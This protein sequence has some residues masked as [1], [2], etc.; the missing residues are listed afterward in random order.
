MKNTWLTRDVALLSVAIFFSDASNGSTIPI[1]PGYAKQL[2]ASLSVLGTYGSVAAVA[3]LLLSIPLGRLSDRLGRKSVIIP[4]LAL[5]AVVQFSYT[6]ASNPLHLYPIRIALGVATGMIFVNG[7]LL[8]TEVADER[9]RSLAGGLYMT[10]MGLGFTLGPLAGGLTAKLYGP[11][12]SFMM[13]C[14]LAVAGLL[15]L[16]MVKETRKTAAETRGPALQLRELLRDP[17]ILASGVANF[18]NSLMFNAVTLF[19][20]VYGADIGLDQAQIGVGL[21]SRGLASTVVRLPVGAF[22]SRVGAL[23]LMVAGLVA[24]AVTLFS[25][26]YA[27]ALTLVTVLMGLQGLAYGVYLTSGNVY[28]SEEAPSGLKGTSMAIYGMFGNIGGIVGPL[29]LGVMAENAGTS[30]ALQ[31]A[32]AASVVGVGL[33]MLLSRRNSASPGLGS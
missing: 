26:S 16:L 27:S 24:S 17:K 10:S 20:P 18:I 6:V 29:V 25:V 33:T 11:K 3:I 7:F 8:M 23:N 21:T 32:A 15:V 22:T 12:A 1:F 14:G 19:F 13:S 2:G 31:F 9:S 30:G 28:V 5:L 4:G